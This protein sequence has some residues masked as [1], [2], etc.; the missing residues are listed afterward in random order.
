MAFLP[1]AW[2]PRAH[3]LLRIIAGL[4]FLMHGTQKLFTFPDPSQNMAGAPPMVKVGGI[5]EL[6][7]GALI[8]IGL[9]TRIAAFL[10]S[11]EMAVAYFVVHAKNGFWPIMNQGEL[12]VLYCF[13]FFY[14]AF[15]G[16]GP[17]SVD[18]ALPRSRATSP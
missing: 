7:C 16:A 12:A 14:F 2:A 5:I 8:A 17:W 1:T 3:S 6:V 9:L 11:G 10:A 18:A 15:A 4:M 13:V